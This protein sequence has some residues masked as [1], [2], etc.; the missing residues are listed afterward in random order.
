MPGAPHP[1]AVFQRGGMPEKIFGQSDHQPQGMLRDRRMVDPGRKQHRQAPLRRIGYI[2]R[3][4]ADP[5]LGNYLETRPGRVDDPG[6]DP[7]IA[8]Q[9][10][11]KRA[12]RAD[13]R[14]QRGLV[15][16]AAR[17]HDLVPAGSQQGLM[18]PRRILQAG[19]GEQD[20]HLT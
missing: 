1:A 13:Q 19:G 2:N 20:S 9:Q 11:V 18:R 12:V 7:V 8:I 4:E 3:V 17:P 16:G 5:V 10:P 14:E 15:K 6:R